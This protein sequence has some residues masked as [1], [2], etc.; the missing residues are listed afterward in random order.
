MKLA[1]QILPVYDQMLGTL[2]GL[3]DKAEAHNPSGK[4]LSAR[5]AEDMFPLATQIRFLANMPGESLARIA[6]LAFASRE[7]DPADV[8]EAR[9]FVNEARALVAAARDR[10]FL[11]PDDPVELALPNGMTFD[12][13]AEQYVRDW[14]LPQF[15][16]HLVT[17]Y[18]VLR[19]HGLAIGK[20]DY[21]P[22]MFRYIRK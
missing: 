11:A 14:A 4:I 9:A 7:E 5:I 13:T 6:G 19:A 8:G 10:S 22:Y 17:A 1:D 12:L 18:A 21:V 2:A 15:Y 3:V 16:F 20:P